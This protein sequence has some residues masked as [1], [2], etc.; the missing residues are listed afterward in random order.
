MKRILITVFVLFLTFSPSYTMVDGVEKKLQTLHSSLTLLKTK[1]AALEDKLNEIQQKL[2]PITT[3]DPITADE[4]ADTF[5]VDSTSLA[6]QF[7]GASFYNYTHRVGGYKTVVLV[8]TVDGKAFVLGSCPLGYEEEYNRIR[9]QQKR[10]NAF[11]FTIKPQKSGK[12]DKKMKAVNFMGSQGINP[13]DRAQIQKLAQMG[14]SFTKENDVFD[15]NP[16]NILVK[17]DEL[18]YIDKDLK[19][20]PKPT[21][22]FA[23]LENIEASISI[24]KKFLPETSAPAEWEKVYGYIL[25]AYTQEVKSLDSK[26]FEEFRT[27]YKKSLDFIDMYHNHTKLEDEFNYLAKRRSGEWDAP[28]S[29]LEE[30]I[31]QDL[32]KIFDLF[33]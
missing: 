27:D 17:D 14:M 23:L 2:N 31:V 10:P 1:L 19:Y 6:A 32:R 12:P 33:K 18:Y 5:G 4:A 22:C 15:E 8:R 7:P 25:D 11:F 29:D 20:L 28:R 3:E 30:R 26:T 9:K 16:G 13:L 24:A 21:M